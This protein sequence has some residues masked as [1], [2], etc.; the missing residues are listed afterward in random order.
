MALR[1]IRFRASAGAR[2][3]H[4]ELAL[5]IPNPE[6]SAVNVIYADREANCDADV[7]CK[8][9]DVN[10][11]NMLK[12]APVFEAAVRDSA[13][14]HRKLPNYHDV[15]AHPTFVHVVDMGLLRTCFAENVFC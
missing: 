11:D 10:V 5:C 9:L 15:R 1:V 7:L 4:F 13:E 3:D 8:A 2:R 14:L 6:D 12:K